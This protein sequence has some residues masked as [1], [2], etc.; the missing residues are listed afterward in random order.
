MT[1]SPY[2]L[3]SSLIKPIHDPEILAAKLSR[4]LIR[5][6]TACFSVRTHHIATSTQKQFALYHAP[7]IDLDAAISHAKSLL[8]RTENPP[9]SAD[10]LYVQ[11]AAKFYRIELMDGTET[12]CIHLNNDFRLTLT[13]T[14]I[15]IDDVS[16]MSSP[17]LRYFK[18]LSHEQI[19]EF[20]RD[21]VM[22]P[23]LL[24]EI[25]KRIFQALERKIRIDV[26]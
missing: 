25:G 18:F 24:E 20:K 22:K 23:D 26:D 14:A 6:D 21:L 10:I 15:Q 2:F 12:I 8:N 5:L 7:L 9:L 3:N 13:E 1:T 19:I 11:S 16:D 17:R 4:S